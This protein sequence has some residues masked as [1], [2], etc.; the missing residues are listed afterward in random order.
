MKTIETK[1]QELFGILFG[2]IL[3]FIW[4]FILT[5]IEY[6]LFS[7]KT[8]IQGTE[9]TKITISGQVIEWLHVGVILFFIIVGHYLLYSKNVGGIEK[10]Q[11]IIA[12]KSNL[13]GFLIWLFVSVITYILQ[14]RIPYLINIGG[15]YFT[16]IFLYLL[17]K[18][19]KE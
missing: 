10:N 2:V 3:F 12:M 19:S 4:L 16:I 6:M 18:R 7:E 17:M 5:V 11:D 13:L 8:I 9:I 1:V 15:G 14:I